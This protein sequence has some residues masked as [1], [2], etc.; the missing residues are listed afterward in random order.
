MSL[1]NLIFLFSMQT[2]NYTKKPHK[3]IGLICIFNLQHT[4]EVHIWKTLIVLVLKY[5]IMQLLLFLKKVIISVDLQYVE[6]RFLLLCGEILTVEIHPLLWTRVS[7]TAAHPV[8]CPCQVLCHCVTL[9]TLLMEG[10]RSCSIKK[11][12][13]GY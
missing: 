10:L 1:S 11:L 12:P 6:S 8:H 13:H 2:L 7:K 4:V 5:K 3:T 9:R